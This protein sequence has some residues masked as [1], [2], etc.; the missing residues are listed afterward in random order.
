VSK[1]AP[2]APTASFEPLRRPARGGRA[3]LILLGPLAWLAMLFVVAL[4]VERGEAVEIALAVL[5]VS[6]LLSLVFLLWT[7]RARDQE[8]QPASE[9]V[10]E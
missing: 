1:P 6:F 2:P 7:R 10:S 3:V 5:A 4:L 9:P 8:E